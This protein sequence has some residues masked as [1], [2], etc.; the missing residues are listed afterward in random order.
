MAEN[1]VSHTYEVLNGNK[2]LIALSEIKG[3]SSCLLCQK[4]DRFSCLNSFL[5]PP[6]HESSINQVKNQ[7]GKFLE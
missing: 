7:L 4:L 5:I 2:N 6:S 1:P 3:Y